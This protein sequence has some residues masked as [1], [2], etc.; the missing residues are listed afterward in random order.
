MFVIKSAIKKTLSNFRR[1]HL[2][3]WRD[4]KLKFTD[5]QLYVITGLL[6]SPNYYA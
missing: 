5:D 6:V 3:S 4:H 2:D 1:T